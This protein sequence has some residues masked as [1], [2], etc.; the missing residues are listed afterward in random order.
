MLTK[1]ELTEAYKNFKDQKILHL[2]KN[3]SKSLREEAVAILENEIIKR[4][5]DKKLLD[6]IKLE[7][8]FF[9]GAELLNLKQIIKNSEC[10]DCGKKF[11]DIQ[12]FHIRSISALE[13]SRNSKLILCNNCGKKMRK[14]AYLESATLGFLSLYGIFRV[15]F[16]FITELIAS[17]SRNIMSNKIIEEFIFQNTGLIRKHGVE[18]VQ[19]YCTA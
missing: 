15:P 5:L 17:F 11:N 4:K 16:Y 9:N 13:F 12:G 14:K 18:N 7:R 10:N 3:D 1:E 6:W 2:A 8:N 19:S